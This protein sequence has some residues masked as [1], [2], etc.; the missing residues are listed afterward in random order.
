M[1]CKAVVQYILICLWF[2]DCLML[3]SLHYTTAHLLVPYSK[4][5]QTNDYE[6]SYIY[7][8]IL[9]YYTCISTIYKTIININIYYNDKYEIHLLINTYLIAFCP[10]IEK[11]YGIILNS[12]MC[13]FN[14]FLYEYCSFVTCFYIDL[15]FSRNVT[16]S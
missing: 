6:I 12:L 16:I 15:D 4:P 1:L 13:I 5:R 3:L 10:C 8:N 9:Y 2:N 14:L 11:S 7:S